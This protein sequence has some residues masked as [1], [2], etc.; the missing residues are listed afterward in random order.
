MK[1][2]TSRTSTDLV[3]RLDEGEAALQLLTPQRASDLNTLT[4]LCAIAEGDC[5]TRSNLEQQIGMAV[6]SYFSA[7]H[8]TSSFFL[9]EYREAGKQMKQHME[10]EAKLLMSGNGAAEEFEAALLLIHGFDESWQSE[11]IEKVTALLERAA[12]KGLEKAQLFLENDWPKI[13]VIFRKRLER[14]KGI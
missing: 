4:L 7:V 5:D 1:S 3:I 14:D 9:N 12:K 6:L 13:S 2:V 11:D 10:T 8:S